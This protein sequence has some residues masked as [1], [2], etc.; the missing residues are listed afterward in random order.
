MLAGTQ[1]KCHG[2]LTFVSFSNQASTIDRGRPV[3]A[4]TFAP[5]RVRIATD[6]LLS[7]N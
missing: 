7:V 6:L 2:S 1:P 3:R 4:S 5:R